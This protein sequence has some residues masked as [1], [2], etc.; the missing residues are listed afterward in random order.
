V[1][2]L[3]AQVEG[4]S[5]TWPT[6]LGRHAAALATCVPGLASL[7]ISATAPG[8]LHDRLRQLP[9]PMGRST[10]SATL[11]Q[12]AKLTRLQRLSVDKELLVG[13]APGTRTTALRLWPAA[14]R[15]RCRAWCVRGSV[16]VH[17]RAWV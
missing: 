13:A 12:L 8:G 10:A 3:T 7:H 4:T 5:G 2:A 6:C 9:E 11:V 16:C 1:Q 14:W 17:R 15:P